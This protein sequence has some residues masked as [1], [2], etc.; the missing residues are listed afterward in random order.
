[1][2]SLLHSFTERH[3]ELMRLGPT[4]KF[5]TTP[6]NQAHSVSVLH[7]VLLSKIS[8]YAV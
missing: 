6:V 7:A 8:K 1:M 4:R 5:V 3:L 2:Y